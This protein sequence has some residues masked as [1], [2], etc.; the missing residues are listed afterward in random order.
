MFSLACFIR[1]VALGTNFTVRALHSWHRCILLSVSEFCSWVLLFICSCYWCWSTPSP[2][3]LIS[4]AWFST[5]GLFL[6]LVFQLPLFSHIV[7]WYSILVILFGWWISLPHRLLFYDFIISRFPAPFYRFTG[8]YSW[9]THRILHNCWYHS[10]NFDGQIA[11]HIAFCRDAFFFIGRLAVYYESCSHFLRIIDVCLWDVCSHL[12]FL[13]S[14]FIVFWGLQ[15]KIVLCY[16]FWYTFIWAAEFYST[17][18]LTMICRTWV[19]PHS[20]RYCSLGRG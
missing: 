7:S 19:P 16:S 5:T 12:R 17:F 8:R 3:V 11:A 13:W 9:T 10:Y 2:K 6:F 4:C 20:G 15:L 14:F 18:R 1:I